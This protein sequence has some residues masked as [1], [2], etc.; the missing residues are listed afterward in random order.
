MRVTQTLCSNPETEFS[1]VTLILVRAVFCLAALVPLLACSHRPDPNT[2]V[3]IIDSSP[4]NLD[5]RV[6]LDASSERIDGLLFDNL[7]THDDHFNVRPG[8]AERWDTPD[9]LTYIF[10]LHQG[11]HFHNGAP[12]ASRDVKWSFDSLIQGKVHSAKG[13]TFRFVKL[14]ET[15]DDYTVIF[16][17]KE[18]FAGLLWNLSGSAMGIVPYGSGDEITQHPIGSGPFQFIRAAQDEEVV[19]A[20][21]EDYWS[22]KAGLQRIRFAVIPDPTTRALELRK[23]SADIAI[24]SFAS[25]DTVRVLEQDP[26]LQILHGPGTSLQYLGL[27]TRDPILKDVRVRQ[28]IACAIDRKPFIHYIFGDFARPAANILP[29]E[30]W[31]YNSAVHSFTHD[32]EL[33]RKLLDSAGYPEVNG[34][35]FRLT[36]KTSTEEFGRLLAA[37]LQQQ[38]REVG[39]ELEIRSFEF[40]TFL[41]DVTHGEFQMYSLRWAGGNE[42]PDM[43]DYVFNSARSTPKGANR[44]FYSNHQVD[45]LIDQARREPDQEKRKDLYAQIQTILADEL[46]SIN[47]WYLNNVMVANRRVINLTLNLSGNYD[48]LKT[49]QLS[50]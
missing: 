9:P 10:H 21:N 26:Q 32:P 4:A 38:L 5:P 20:R 41:S 43:F 22:E 16:H 37:V 23:G 33:A 17:L 28:A 30:S 1:S 14:I 2:L 39:I 44:S 34:I 27:N 24:N 15:P 7:L 13:D 48:F 40:A 8:L 47:L 46:P 36:M 31:A 29:P 6:G 50:H 35:R 12:L 49:A 42:D 25:A 11:V 18:P 3:M 19:I 45:L